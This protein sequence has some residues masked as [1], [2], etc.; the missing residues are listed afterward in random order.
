MPCQ[1][2]LALSHAGQN[3]R[4]LRPVGRTVGGAEWLLAYPRAVIH[5]VFLADCPART[6]LELVSHRWSVVVIH[7]LGQRPMRFGELQARIGGITPKSLTATLHRLADNG[8]VERLDGRWT[9]SPLGETLLEPV[10]TLAR[11][12]E[13]HTDALVDARDRHH[14]STST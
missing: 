3:R 6:T 10:S 8:L 1:D 14:A 9:L 12:A 11:W 7:G 5:D 13:Q 2:A 4:W